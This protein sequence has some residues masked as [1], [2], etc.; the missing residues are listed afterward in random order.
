MV[1]ATWMTDSVMHRNILIL[2][3]FSFPLISQEI[4]SWAADTCG[5]VVRAVF[6]HYLL[7]IIHPKAI[8]RELFRYTQVEFCNKLQRCY[9]LSKAQTQVQSMLL[10][11][12]HVTPWHCTIF[13][14]KH[15]NTVFKHS[16]YHLNKSTM[17][18]LDIC[19][20]LGLHLQKI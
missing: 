14:F 10:K 16:C 1:S 15:F 2:S 9:V 18:L 13:Q 17:F 19:F 7:H 8:K 6:H 3:L 12:R 5:F 4:L 11:Q 20:P